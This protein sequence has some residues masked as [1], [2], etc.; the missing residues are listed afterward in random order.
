MHSASRSSEWSICRRPSLL[1]SAHGV[2]V[3][4]ESHVLRGLTPAHN[5]SRQGNVAIDLAPNTA[6]PAPVERQKIS[7]GVIFTQQRGS[8]SLRGNACIEVAQTVLA[9]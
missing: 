8:H 9:G 3:V 7:S 5:R 2:P 4:R 1:A 6:S